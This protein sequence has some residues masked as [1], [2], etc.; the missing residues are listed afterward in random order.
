MRLSVAL[1]L[2]RVGCVQLLGIMYRSKFILALGLALALFLAD[3]GVVA[4]ASCAAM[5]EEGCVAAGASCEAMLGAREGKPTQDGFFIVRKANQPDGKKFTA[6]DI[7]YGRESYP[8]RV[9]NYYKRVPDKQQS[10]AHTSS[11][12][13]D[14]RQSSSQ[15]SSQRSEPRVLK[16][17]LFSR[18]ASIYAVGELG[19]T[20]LVAE[21]GKG[22]VWRERQ[23]Q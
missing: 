14:T 9:R 18:D 13:S 19:D 3:S 10:S 21:G 16:P 5:Q 23:P 2:S 12:R 4:S 1:T 7:V 22:I 20:T 15:T 6:H 8:A 11:R 17:H